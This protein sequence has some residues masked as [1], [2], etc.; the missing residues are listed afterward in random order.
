MTTDTALSGLEAIDK[1]RKACADGK[2]YDLVFL[3]HL[4]PEMDGVETAKRIR[5]LGDDPYFKSLPLIALSANVV[6]GAREFFLSSGMNDFLAKPFSGEQLNEVLLKWLP[7][8]KLFLL[9]GTIAD[10]PKRRGQ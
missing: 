2:P 8:G 4:M 7:K 1:I 10:K 3:D 5:A 9:F 6:G